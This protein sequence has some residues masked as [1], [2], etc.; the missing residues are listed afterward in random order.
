MVTKLKLQEKPRNPSML[1]KP[2]LVS[3]GPMKKIPILEVHALK[4]S[5]F[6]LKGWWLLWKHA[7]P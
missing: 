6:S 1:K 2:D 7:S 5:M 3:I 4:S